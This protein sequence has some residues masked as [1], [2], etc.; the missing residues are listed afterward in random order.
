MEWIG[1]I[2]FLACNKQT[3][4][5]KYIPTYRYTYLHTDIHTYIYVKEPNGLDQELFVFVYLFF[6]SYISVKESSDSDLV[7]DWKYYYSRVPI[8][9]L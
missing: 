3:Y 5:H 2:I 9:W 8:E 4:L 7:S 6:D 1:L